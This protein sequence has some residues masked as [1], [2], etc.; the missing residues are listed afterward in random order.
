MLSR[1]GLSRSRSESQLSREDNRAGPVAICSAQ[2][3]QGLLSNLF[4]Y[5]EQHCS[6]NAAPLLLCSP[7]V[8]LRAHAS[9]A[10]SASSQHPVP[11]VAQ[12]IRP[13]PASP[14]RGPPPLRLPQ[15]PSVPPAAATLPAL[16]PPLAQG[17]GAPPAPPRGRGPLGQLLSQ[18]LHLLAQEGCLA[19]IGGIHV[20]VLQQGGQGWAFFKGRHVALLGGR[21]VFVRGCGALQG[22]IGAKMMADRSMHT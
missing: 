6:C 19:V 7:P 9:P 1:G 15:T 21:G 10:L 20:H 17:T 3:Y 12:G 14:H 8:V 18:H 2:R 11:V 5:T 16:R 13:R 4:M 22:R